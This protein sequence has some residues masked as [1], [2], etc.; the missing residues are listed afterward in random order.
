MILITYK[1][2]LQSQSQG[3]IE[4]LIIPAVIFHSN[5]RM[6][7]TIN[8]KKQMKKQ[9][10]VQQMYLI[11]NIY[12]MVKMNTVKRQENVLNSIHKCKNKT[13]VYQGRE[14]YPGQILRRNYR[15]HFN[16]G[17]LMSLSWTTCHWHNFMIDP[18]CCSS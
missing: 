2:F 5:I 3:F 6:S 14:Q 4:L 12:I 8:A 16:S 1:L 13:K 15:S 9:R 7:Y 10:G 11:V 18:C 17:K